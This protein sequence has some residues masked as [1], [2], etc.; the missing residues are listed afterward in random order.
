MINSSQAVSEQ[1]NTVPNKV[2]TF[3]EL[4]DDDEDEADYDDGEDEDEGLG[5]SMTERWYS[6]AGFGSPEWWSRL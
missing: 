5:H 2:W 6:L 1:T 3:P 4:D